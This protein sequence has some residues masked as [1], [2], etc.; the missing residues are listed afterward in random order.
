[1]WSTKCMFLPAI[2]LDLDR[3]KFLWRKIQC[4]K[5]FWLHPS[6]CILWRLPLI[7]FLLQPMLKMSYSLYLLSICVSICCVTESKMY[8]ICSIVLD[9]LIFFRGFSIGWFIVCTCTEWLRL[10]AHLH[11]LDLLLQHFDMGRWISGCSGC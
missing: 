2:I 10:V 5:P 6:F 4:D 7:L 3:M 1:M 11:W 9:Q 8:Y